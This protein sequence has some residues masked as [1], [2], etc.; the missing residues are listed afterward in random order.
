MSVDWDSMVDSAT[1]YEIL[2][3][4]CSELDQNNIS[5]AKIGI[6]RY[7]DLLAARDR[8]TITSHL[9]RIM[10]HVIKWKVQPERNSSSSWMDSIIEARKG[11]ESVCSEHPSLNRAFIESRWDVVFKR[12]FRDARMEMMKS[13]N[14]IPIRSLTWE[15]VF[16]DDYIYDPRREI[17][18]LKV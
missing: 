9:G 13:E 17:V 11:I 16:E 8:S 7:K 10:K 14:D 12:A 15:E 1:D 6:N 3:A 18:F 2:D 5:S 4:V